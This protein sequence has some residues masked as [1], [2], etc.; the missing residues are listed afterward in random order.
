[1][2]AAAAE[3]GAL[4]GS[5]GRLVQVVM[6]VRWVA[7]VAGLFLAPL[8]IWPGEASPSAGDVALVTRPVFQRPLASFEESRAT[9]VVFQALPDSAVLRAWGM[10]IYAVYATRPAPDDDWLLPFSRIGVMVNATA[11]GRPVEVKPNAVQ[12][13]A[14]SSD[15]ADTNVGF[16]PPS[17]STVE[18]VLAVSPDVDRPPGTLV[19]RPFWPG[20]KDR[21][22]SVGL[23]YDLHKLRTWLARAGLGVLLLVVLKKRTA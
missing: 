3:A 8:T 15:T 11:D 1:M 9:T 22:V 18:V 21:L 6:G 10:P 23:E 19:I 13:Y 16:T 2:R 12:V 4:G 14:H 7:V 17:G 20:M 5:H